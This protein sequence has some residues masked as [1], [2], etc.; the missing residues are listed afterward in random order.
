PLSSTLPP[1]PAAQL[2]GAPA[3]GAALEGQ[4]EACPAPAAVPKKKSVRVGPG[5]GPQ[6][7]EGLKK[8]WSRRSARNA[9]CWQAARGGAARGRPAGEE[10]EEE[11]LG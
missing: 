7:A 9:C 11:D 4:P 2:G 5:R 10:E 6:G 1:G 3:R 8:R